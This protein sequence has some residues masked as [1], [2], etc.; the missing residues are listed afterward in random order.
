MPVHIA[1]LAPFSASLADQLELEI[2]ASN[3]E[4][5]GGFAE[6]G[7][8]GAAAIAHDLSA[9]YHRY[10]LPA[11]NNAGSALQCLIRNIKDKNFFVGL[12]HASDV[13]VREHHENISSVK[14]GVEL[15]CAGRQTLYVRLSVQLVDVHAGML[16]ESLCHATA[17]EFPSRE[18]TNLLALRL[19]LARNG[20]L[21]Q[22][23]PVRTGCLRSFGGCGHERSTAN[24]YRGDN[25][26]KQSWGEIQ[27]NFA[28]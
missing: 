8:D 21:V 15:F 9:K 17:D 28:R 11:S 25:S 22:G 4:S 10:G 27:C 2:P 13:S 5:A 16:F 24:K 1:T 23:D 26:G 3:I 14:S 12:N 6:S 18:P 19:R 20:R 7:L